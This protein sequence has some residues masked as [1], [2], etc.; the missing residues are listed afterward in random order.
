MVSKQGQVITQTALEILE[1][2]AGCQ[3]LWSSK[4]YIQLT[5]LII[6]YYMPLFNRRSKHTLVAWNDALYVFGGDNGYVLWF[7]LQGPV[8]RTPVNTNPGLKFNPG[9]FFFLSKALSRIIFSI[10]FSISNHQI[11]GKENSTEL[12]FK[13]LISEFKIFTNSGV[14][15]TQLRT[16]RPRE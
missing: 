16:T 1:A 9:F 10:F 2:K 14:I 4:V 6:D 5:L 12:A 15:L 13:A 3:S 7:V 11:V 8:V